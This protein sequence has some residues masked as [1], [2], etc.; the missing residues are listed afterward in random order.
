VSAAQLLLPSYHRLWGCRC[1]TQKENTQVS[2]LV[3]GWML[4]RHFLAFLQRLL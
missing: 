4:S 3:A 2:P 1:G